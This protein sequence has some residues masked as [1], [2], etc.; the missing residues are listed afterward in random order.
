MERRGLR[1]VV[2][3]CVLL[4]GVESCIRMNPGDGVEKTKSAATCAK[5][6][7]GTMQV[8]ADKSIT[9]NDIVFKPQNFEMDSKCACNNGWYFNIK[10]KNE[11]NPDAFGDI[12]EYGVHVKCAGKGICMC[13]TADKCYQNTDNTVSVVLANYCAKATKEGACTDPNAR[14][15]AIIMS[16][17]GTEGFKPIDGGAT[18]TAGEGYNADGKPKVLTDP[19]YLSILAVSCGKCPFA[20]P[21]SCEKPAQDKP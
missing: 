2:F 14:M 5:A 20:K 13:D 12:P 10:G 3:M 17:T 4:A 21:A 15:K 7:A 19:S 9:E 18:K 16:D 11:P 6:D 1:W 8:F